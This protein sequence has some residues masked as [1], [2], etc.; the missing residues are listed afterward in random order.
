[1]AIRKI[2]IPAAGGREAFTLYAELANI[3]FFIKAPLTPTDVQNFSNK[4]VAV[5][6]HTRRRFPGDPAPINVSATSREFLVDPTRR[7]G[8]ALPGREVVL[9]SDAGFPGEER[10]TF[11]LKGR[12]VDFH[13]WL[14]ANAKMQI[15]A[16][17]HTG[18]WS[19]IDAAVTP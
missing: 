18:A 9:V 10:R 8:N 15:H 3:N 2:V 19:T 17:N 14:V 4:S 13:A 7:S 1:M 6:A 11:T 12:W 5:K 16:Y